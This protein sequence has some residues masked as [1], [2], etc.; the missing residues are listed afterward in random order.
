MTVALAEDRDAQLVVADAPP[1]A[2]R[3][4][5]V[6]LVGTVFASAA[7]VMF[8]V[9]LM[10]VYLHLRSVGRLH[11]GTWLPQAVH[12]PL[13]QPNV[14]LFTLLMSSF[15]VQWAVWAAA[16]DDRRHLYLSI[17]VS[18]LLAFAFLNQAAYLYTLMGLDVH[19]N[20]QS[21]L[22][23]TI[24]GAQLVMLVVAMIFLV[25]MGFRALVGQLTSRQHDGIS[26]AAIFWHT[27]WVVYLLIWFA[28]YVTK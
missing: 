2:P 24:T 26:A 12:I 1:P 10:G 4:P 5:R 23:Y 14:M 17:G 18:L 16:H 3:R 8:F 27:T 19:G 11:G 7:C 25:L 15:T 6:L 20:Q 9:G 21:V 28:I 13:T 22:I